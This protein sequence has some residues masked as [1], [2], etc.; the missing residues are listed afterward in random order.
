M[1]GDC[2]AMSIRAEVSKYLVGS[3]ERWFAVD[4]P[5]QRVKLPDQT[6][7]EVGVGQTAQET[8]ELELPGSMRLLERSDEFAAEEFAKN[9]FREEEAG[10]AGV[11]PTRVIAG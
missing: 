1:V 3:P 2:Y 7:E 4:H 9:R 10:I 5:V 8:V 11:H 6:P